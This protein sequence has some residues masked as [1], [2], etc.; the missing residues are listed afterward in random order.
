MIKKLLFLS[1]LIMVNFYNYANAEVITHNDN[2]KIY[3]TIKFKSGD[4]KA[5][6]IL[7]NF[8]INTES[9]RILKLANIQPEE[10]VAYKVNLN[11]YGEDEIIGYIS[12]GPYWSRE[13]WQLFI[14]QMKD[15]HY[16]NLA[17]HNFEPFDNV[18]IM[19]NKINGYR[20]IKSYVTNLEV[21]LRTKEIEHMSTYMHYEN[22]KYE[23]D[24]SKK[25][26]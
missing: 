23:Y 1:I 11:D 26:K 7:Y 3:Q 20:E 10:I 22:G 19:K 25:G 5:N 17:I 24:Y 6:R 12:R 21:F 8:L 16:R 14:L 9:K 15:G 18:Y 4:P 2:S 13:G